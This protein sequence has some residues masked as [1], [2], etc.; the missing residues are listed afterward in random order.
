MTLL[1]LKLRW[2]WF[3]CTTKKLYGFAVLVAILYFAGVGLTVSDMFTP[4]PNVDIGRHA[5][6]FF[7]LNQL[8][9]GK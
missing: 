8:D 7:N 1:F 2:W 6:A 3:Y 5:K 4:Q 9:V